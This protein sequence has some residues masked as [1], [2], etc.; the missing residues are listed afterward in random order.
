MNK[1]HN[2]LITGELGG[3]D[4]SICKYFYVLMRKKILLDQ[5]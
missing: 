1:I 5:Q 2:V 3:I 4:L